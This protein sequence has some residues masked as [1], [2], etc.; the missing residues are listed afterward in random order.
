MLHADKKKDCEEHNFTTTAEVS[1]EES[2][3]DR[4]GKRRKKKKQFT[5]CVTGAFSIM[6]VSQVTAFLFTHCCYIF[7]FLLIQLVLLKK[8]ATQKERMF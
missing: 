1:D 5:D 3:D 4:I 7:Y 8:M 6:I 2:G